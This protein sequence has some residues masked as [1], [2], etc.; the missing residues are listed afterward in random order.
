VALAYIRHEIYQVIHLFDLYLPEVLEEAG[1]EH[2]VEVLRL[3]EEGIQ[4]IIIFI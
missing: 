3:H 4:R 2:V 1:R